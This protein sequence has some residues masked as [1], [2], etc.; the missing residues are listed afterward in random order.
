[1]IQEEIFRQQDICLADFKEWS[2]HSKIFH[3]KLQ[4]PTVWVLKDLQN[5]YWKMFCN[6]SLV[7]QITLA[8]VCMAYE[9]FLTSQRFS[10]NDTVDYENQRLYCDTVLIC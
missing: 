10:E 2:Y 5:R 1:M 7:S 6:E 4:D 9:S 8:F 3:K